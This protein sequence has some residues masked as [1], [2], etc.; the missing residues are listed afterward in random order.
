[1]GSKRAQPHEHFISRRPR[2]AG[3][4]RAAGTPHARPVGPRHRLAVHRADDGVAAAD[5]HLPADL[6]GAAV[7][8]Q[9]PRN[10]PNAEVIGVGI[11]HYV[12]ILTDP[13]IWGP[14]QATAHFL[15]WTITLQTLDRLRPGLADRPQVP[16][17][18]FLDHADPDSDD[19]VAGG[20]G[21]LLGLHLPA[22]DRAVQLRR[23]LLHR[24]PAVELRDARVRCGSRPG[25]S[26]SST[27]GCGHPT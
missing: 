6:D 12:S 5:Q 20:G 27:P 25:P 15:F 24:H 21:Q 13:D 18:R 14:M 10:R 2:R 26:S 9:L 17:P 23:V 1:M 8:H 7:V 19:V 11:D 22:A 4:A 16:R 3:H